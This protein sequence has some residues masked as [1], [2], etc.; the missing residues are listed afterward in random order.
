[1]PSFIVSGGYDRQRDT[2]SSIAGRTSRFL[3]GTGLQDSL[4]TLHPNQKEEA[5]LSLTSN[6]KLLDS[7]TNSVEKREQA[8]LPNPQATLVY[9]ARSNKVIAKLDHGDN[10]NSGHGRAK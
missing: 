8:S 3:S 7:D 1:M 6:M 2:D 10:N 4:N 5:R 9:L